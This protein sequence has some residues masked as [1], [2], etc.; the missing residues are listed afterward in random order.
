[1]KMILQ[2]TVAAGIGIPDGAGTEGIP[3]GAE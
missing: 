2:W 1:M 3:D